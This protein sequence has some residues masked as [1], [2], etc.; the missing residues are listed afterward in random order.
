VLVTKVR[1]DGVFDGFV[2]FPDG[3]T[4]IPKGYSFSLPPEIPE[5]YYAILSGGWKLINGDKPEYPP[6]P[7]QEE[8]LQKLY[9][10]VVDKTQQRLDEFARTREYESILSAC[11]YST[12]TVEKFRIEGQYCV[13]ARDATWNKLFQILEEV[14][15]EQRPTPTSYDD[16][17]SDLPILEWPTEQK[18]TGYDD[19]QSD[20]PIL[21]EPV[22]QQ[23]E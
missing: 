19:I 17:Q 4:K 22:E 3:T 15:T 14:Q 2:E 7:S 11:T 1:E 9:R 8:L 12:S 20:L 6:K 23:E 10:D 18:P 5:G 21:E 16:I 13:E